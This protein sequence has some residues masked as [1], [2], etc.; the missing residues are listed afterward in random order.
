M[1][2]QSFSRARF[3]VAVS[4]GAYPVVTLLL[5]AMGPFTAEWTVWQRA[6]AMVPIMV[7]AMVWGVIPAV[8]RFAGSWL[9]SPA[10]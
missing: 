1:S 2:V 10:G 6:L 9:R 5:Y 4:I 8:H 3:A 7:T